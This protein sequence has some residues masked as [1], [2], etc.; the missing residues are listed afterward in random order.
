MQRH[1]ALHF[2]W[3][4]A[5]CAPAPGLAQAPAT[6]QDLII[7]APPAPVE[8]RT[9][10]L[11]LSAGTQHL[12]GPYGNWRDMTLT[13]GWSLPG[14]VLQG[15]LSSHRRFGVG[16]TYLGVGD[17]YRFDEDWYGSATLG[18]GDGAFY[19]PKYRVDATLNRKFLADRR[20]VGTLGAGYYRAPD[21]H[22]DRSVLLG[23]TYYF[24]APWIVEGGVRFNE[25]APGSVN[26][27]QHFV[28]LTWGRAKADLVT[29]RVGWGG[30]GYLATGPAT[31]LVNFTSREASIAWRHWIGQN[32]GLL[33]A[34]NRYSNPLYRRAGA[35]VGLFHDF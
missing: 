18:A 7:P 25:S 14:H 21:G 3:L 28:A 27:R 24:E 17:T 29:A 23:A 20:L 6:G 12:S 10:S 1:P 9:R 16:G 5:L 4:L 26:T 11:Q 34:V 2:L 31:Q 19:L 13:G 33:L 30:E 22:S 32:T 35:T 8:E 15:E